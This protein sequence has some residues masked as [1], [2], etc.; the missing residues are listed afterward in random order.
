MIWMNYLLLHKHMCAI[1]VGLFGYV[2]YNVYLYMYDN[3][4]E[5]YPISNLYMTNH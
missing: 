2:G 4:I 3:F 1:F 5:F